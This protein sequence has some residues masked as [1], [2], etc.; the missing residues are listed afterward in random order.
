MED[1]GRRTL[2]LFLSRP[3]DDSER[4]TLNPMTHTLLVAGTASHVG[5]STVVAG[6]C[7]LLAAR[8]SLVAPFKAQNMSNNARAVTTPDGGTGEIGISQYTQAHAARIRPTTDMNPVLLKPRGEGESQFVLQGDAVGHYEAGEYYAEHWDRA[9]AVARESW[10]R[11]ASEH[12]CVIAEGAG[13]IAEINLHHRDLANVETARFADADILLVGDIE[14]GGVFASLVGT[15]SLMPSDL[16]ERV[17]GCLITKFRGDRSLLTPGIDS[18]EERTGVPVLGVLPYDDPGLP[19]EDSVSLPSKRATLGADDG[20][21]EERAVTIAVPRLPHISNFTDLEPLARE[22]GVRVAYR[23]LAGGEEFARADAIVIPG[24]KNTVDDCLALRSAGLDDQLRS[25]DGPIVGLCG[26]YQM[27]GQRITNAAVEGTGSVGVID[28][29][30]LLPV[31][32]RFTEAKRVEPV[33]RAIH[34]CG[35]LAGA[36]GVVTGYEIHMGETT[37]LATIDR[38]FEESGAATDRVLGTYMHGLFENETVRDAFLDTVFEC[39]GRERS[40]VTTG[41]PGK[42]ENP[43]DRAATLVRQH[44]DLAPLGLPE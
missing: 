15:L 6:L 26:G 11:L 39:A 23:P 32:T 31:E 8:D 10:V 43:Y 28:G 27:L 34:G 37:L 2:P 22:P 5:K 14:R 12:D 30:G 38:P 25:F 42:T 4:H 40:A 21:R 36:S 13:S 24:T 17:V 19:E 1:A 16:R 9:R 29:I 20:V 44:V 35:P 3:A 41:T 18:F 33:S 7:R